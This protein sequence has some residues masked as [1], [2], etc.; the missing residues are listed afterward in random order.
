MPCTQ[1]KITGKELSECKIGLK[2]DKKEIV[3]WLQNKD[4]KNLEANSILQA[5]FAKV[6]F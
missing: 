6:G 3:Q 1:C 4:I 2:R 5:F